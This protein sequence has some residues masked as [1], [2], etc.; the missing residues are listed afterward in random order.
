M[1][2]WK[3]ITGYEGLYQVSSLG[4]VRALPRQGFTKYGKRNHIH[5]LKP[6]VNYHNKGEYRV[7]YHRVTLCKDG[8][9]KR[10]MVHRL[11]AQAFIPNPDNKPY[12]NHIDCDG[13]HNWVENLEWVTHS[14]NMLWC[15]KLGRCSNLKA[16]EQSKIVCRENAIKF[17]K[18]FYGDAFVGIDNSKKGNYIKAYCA[19]CGAVFSRRMDLARN[20]EYPY[21]CRKCSYKYRFPKHKDIV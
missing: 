15:H 18:A 7:G 19:D 5:Y 1:E 8:I 2:I 11:V 3:D 4:R 13:T 6:D 9:Y 17:G 10:Y 21:V 12:I 16:T 20:A 14:E